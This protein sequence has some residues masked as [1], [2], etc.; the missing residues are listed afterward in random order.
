MSSGGIY[1]FKTN[2]G[3]NGPH[4]RRGN[5]PSRSPKPSGLTLRD[6]S[7]RD[8]GSVHTWRWSLTRV[9]CLT[10]TQTMA[11]SPE[12][13]GGAGPAVLTQGRRL[14]SRQGGRAPHWCDTGPNESHVRQPLTSIH[15]HTTRVSTKRLVSDYYPVKMNGLQIRDQ[16]QW[17]PS[18]FWFFTVF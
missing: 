7:A 14:Q 4:W 6:L 11:G 9:M 1:I 16:I 13:N 10:L 5:V 18:I 8:S 3:E 12:Y 17:C 2:T 15:H